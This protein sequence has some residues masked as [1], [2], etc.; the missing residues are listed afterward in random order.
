MIA[1]NALVR[2]HFFSPRNAGFL[3]LESK[4][5]VFV[6]QGKKA[7]GDWVDV[8]LCCNQSEVILYFRYK[9]LGHPFLIAGLSMYSE[10]LIGKTLDEALRVSHKEMI[11]LLGIPKN[12]YYCA[13]FLEDLM[14]EM[15]N[16]W[17]EKYGKN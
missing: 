2:E 9:V 4:E 17:R 12:K 16:A 5:T 6:S 11:D 10:A 7:L 13:L 3:L 14:G 15:V 1:Y 8:Q